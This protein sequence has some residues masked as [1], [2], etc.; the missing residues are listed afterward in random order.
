MASVTCPACSAPARPGDLICPSCGANL[1]RPAAAPPRQ[2]VEHTDPAPARA[3]AP[4]SEG[5]STVAWTPFCPH[6]GADVPD[7][8]NPTCVECLRPL[9]SGQSQAATL[10]IAFSS[11]EV[12]CAAGDEIALGRDHAESRVADTFRPFDNVSRK[13][14]TIGLDQAGRAWVRDERSTN[15]TYVNDRRL[16]AGE[17]SPLADGDSLRLAADV[18][19]QVYLS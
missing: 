5:P 2:P 13:H 18:I 14:A 4:G 9:R 7:V 16:P 11:G 19:G 8:G 10:R 3:S 12:Q 1:A 6:C 17:E 15:G